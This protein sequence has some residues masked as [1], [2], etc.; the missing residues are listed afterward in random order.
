MTSRILARVAVNL[1]YDVKA[2]EVHGMAQR[3][4]SVVSEVRYGPKVYSPVIKKGDVDILL[5]FE[6]LEAAR[7]IPYLKPGGKVIIND[8]RVDPLPVMTGKAQYPEDI[9]QHIASLVPDTTILDATD[10]AVECGSAKAANVV[11]VGLLAGA[12]DLP[13]AEVE[14]AVREMVPA[15][16]LETNVTAFRRGVEL[17]K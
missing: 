1:G 12:L 15:K 5:A 8:E 10:L 13:Q 7:W 4:G 11:L 14:K 17:C 16:A 9:A 6:K 3:G 2:T